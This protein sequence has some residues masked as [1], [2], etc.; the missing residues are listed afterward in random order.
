MTKTMPGYEVPAQVREMAEKSVDQAKKAFDGFIQQAQQAVSAMEGQAN[1]VQAGAK[2]FNSKAMSFA[3]A[4]VAASFEY[5]QKLVK[6]KDVNEIVRLQ[7][8]YMQAQMKTFGEQAKELGA[9]A[10]KAMTEATKPRS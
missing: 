1:A 8:E 2:D 7:T 5:A 10:T 9:A 3:E 6:A 4:N